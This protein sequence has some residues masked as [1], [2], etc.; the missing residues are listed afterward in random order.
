M[1]LIMPL[2]EF[3]TPTDTSKQID[4]NPS[5]FSNVIQ[6]KL[7]VSVGQRCLNFYYD[8]THRYPVLPPD[9][10]KTRDRALDMRVY[11]SC[12]IELALD[13]DATTGLDWFFPMAQSVITL[14]QATIGDPKTRYKNLNF[15]PE[16]GAGSNL[17]KVLSF[18]ALHYENVNPSHP[19]PGTPYHWR[20]NT[21]K[22]SIEIHLSQLM[23][24]GRP[25]PATLALI[26]DPGIKN[27]GDDP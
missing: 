17:C 4:L 2:S 23:A 9:P 1:P 25:D 20:Q 27:P 19:T 5:A 6:Y 10:Y 15:G 13:D 3:V 11:E 7:H 8:P 24:D 14:E 21:D 22:F 18:D 12:R 16:I 26:I